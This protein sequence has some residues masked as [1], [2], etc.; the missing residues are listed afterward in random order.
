MITKAGQA[1]NAYGTLENM[2][3]SMTEA[4]VIKT[5]CMPI[6]PYLTFED[7][8]KAQ[9]LDPGIMPFTGVDFTSSDSMEQQLK[10]DV[11]QGARGLKLHPIIQKEPLDS[12]KTF[13]AVEVF[14]RFNLPI[15][16]HSG[17][18]SYYL[19][20]EQET[21]E[22]PSYGETAYARKLVAA[23]PQVTFIV[24]HAGIF[25]YKETIG[26][27]SGFKNAYVD[28]SFQPPDRIRELIKA[29]GPERVMYASDWPWGDRKASV[30]AAKKACKG[31]RSLEKLIYYEN[32]ARLLGLPSS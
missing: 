27:L 9:G 13:D 2:Q 26:M 7:L 16:F 12:Q 3:L 24:G 5:A 28:T 22:V 4:G 32:A 20:A 1:R 21:H 19:G 10:G 15:L 31:D 29:F 30:A 11:V 18:T 8:R 23:F 6:A 14:S 17:V 25:Q